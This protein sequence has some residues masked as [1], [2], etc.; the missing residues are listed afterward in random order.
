M[1]S[2]SIAEFLE[3]F[4]RSRTELPI[5]F[6][7][8]VAVLYTVTVIVI[9]LSLR[10]LA[11]FSFLPVLVSEPGFLFGVATSGVNLRDVQSVIAISFAFK[12]SEGVLVDCHACVKVIAPISICQDLRLEI[13][14]LVSLDSAI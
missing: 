9:A 12:L 11:P 7:A 1:S 2:A 8:V 13:V 4:L 14:K 10:S 5:F 6:G 3:I